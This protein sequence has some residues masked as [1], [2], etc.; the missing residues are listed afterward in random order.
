MCGRVI[1]YGRMSVATSFDA[2]LLGCLGLWVAN[3]SGV[4]AAKAGIG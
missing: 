1:G 2:L 3:V 4:V